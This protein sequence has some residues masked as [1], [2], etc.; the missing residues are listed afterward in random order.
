MRTVIH[1]V[2]F[3][4]DFDKEERWLNEMAAKG[5]VLVAVGLC[6][7]E[8]E[9]CIPGGYKIRIDRKSVV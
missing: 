7:Y 9:D 5:F 4:W 1:K 2:F 3:A 6:R 8:F